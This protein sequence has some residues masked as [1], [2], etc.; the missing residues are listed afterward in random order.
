MGTDIKYKE[1]NTPW[2]DKN[3][4]RL[5]LTPSFICMG[6]HGACI[7]SPTYKNCPSV[8]CGNCVCSSSN[9]SIGLE[10]LIEQ[11]FIT[12]GEALAF[13]FDNIGDL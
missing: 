6:E 8:S 10:Y 3:A 12:K 11:K 7:I 4:F 5:G 13:T 1:L 9:L 2:I